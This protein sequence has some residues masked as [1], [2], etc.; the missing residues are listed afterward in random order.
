MITWKKQFYPIV[1]FQQHK[2]Y[3]QQYSKSFQCIFFNWKNM[4]KDLGLRKKTTWKTEKL[5]NNSKWKFNRSTIKLLTS[6]NIEEKIA[7][8]IYIHNS[9]KKIIE[10]L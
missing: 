7:H 3:R 9:N 5:R 2:A 10:D 1:T 4:P 8:N 6:C